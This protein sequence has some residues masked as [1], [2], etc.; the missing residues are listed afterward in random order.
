[1]HHCDAKYRGFKYLSWI[2]QLITEC[3]HQNSCTQWLC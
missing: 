1:M 3:V 2:S